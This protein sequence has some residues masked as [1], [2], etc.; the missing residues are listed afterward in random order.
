MVVGGAGAPAPKKKRGK[1]PV[2]IYYT[3]FKPPQ[4]HTSKSTC[5]GINGS[6]ISTDNQNSSP[7]N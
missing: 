6:T 7:F 5:W 3:P 2:N 1:A 4:L